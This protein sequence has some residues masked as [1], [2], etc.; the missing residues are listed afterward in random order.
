MLMATLELEPLSLLA[1]LSF[2]RLN[3]SRLARGSRQLAIERAM[4]SFSKRHKPIK[5]RAMQALKLRS[6]LR[7]GA[8]T[9][10]PMSLF[11]RLQTSSRLIMTSER[12]FFLTLA[13]LQTK[14]ATIR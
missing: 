2:S 8:Y 6:L 7:L 12:H 11:L 1:P 14:W 3:L 4:S 9:L 13:L 10:V 5:R